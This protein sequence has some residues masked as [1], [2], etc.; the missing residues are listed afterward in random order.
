MSDVE[1][2]RWFEPN[3]IFPL[4]TMSSPPA[5]RQR[6]EDASITRSKVWYNDGS[7]VLQAEN[8]LFRVHWSVLSQHS[9]FF[10]SF[11]D[12]PQPPNQPAVDSCPVV[13]LQDSAVD[14]EHLLTAL[15]DPTFLS[16][17][18]LPLP[19]VGALIRLGRKYDFKNILDSAVARV[20]DQNPT[21]LEEYHAWV[22]DGNYKPTRIISY[23]DYAIDVLTLARA[24][25]IGLALPVAYYRTLTRSTN[26]LLHA[27]QS[28]DEASP[29][30]ALID[31]GRCFVGRQRLV[32]KQFQPGYTLGWL[33]EWPFADCESPAKCSAKRK[34]KFHSYMDR[35]SV[36]PF[37]GRAE[38]WTK[39]LCVPCYQH[40]IE[41]LNAGKAKMW[42]DLPGVFDLP[43][44]SEL[45]NDL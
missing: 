12:L 22:V 11:K 2:E 9:S 36:E 41:S 20:T 27:A 5:K 32:A 29:S 34:S 13:E 37:G 25:N 24:N 14:V 1:P 10:R 39:S 18:A 19:V 31:L 3:P 16:Q 28:K 45:K 42:E 8:T 6:T 40:A 17:T 26:Q 23:P 4:A 44:W 33:R 21:T 30:L 7:V 38:E 35:Q 43:A 15:Y